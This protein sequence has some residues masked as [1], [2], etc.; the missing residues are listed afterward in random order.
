MPFSKL[1]A[2]RE[3]VEKEM[4]RTDLPKQTL[5]FMQDF[6][7]RLTSKLRAAA[8]EAGVKGQFEDAERGWR[9]YLKDFEQPGNPLH[10]MLAGEADLESRTKA[11]TSARYIYLSKKHGFF[12]KDEAEKLAQ[13]KLQPILG[14]PVEL[15]MDGFSEFELK[16]LKVFEKNGKL[17]MVTKLELAFLWLGIM[18]VFLMQVPWAFLFPLAKRFFVFLGDRSWYR[19]WLLASENQQTER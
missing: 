15:L 19:N 14:V 1:R 6:K 5:D 13:L 17:R 2:L 4:S 7:E 11:A 9:E 3:R 10:T 12:S 16:T 18:Q 8:T